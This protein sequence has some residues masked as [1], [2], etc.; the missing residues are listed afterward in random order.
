[1]TSAAIIAFSIEKCVAIIIAI[2]FLVID[3]RTSVY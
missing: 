3:E 2:Y 1:V